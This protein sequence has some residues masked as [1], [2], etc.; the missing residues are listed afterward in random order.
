MLDK[1]NFSIEVAVTN[2]GGAM[3]SDTISKNGRSLKCQISRRNK[4]GL[5][6]IVCLFFVGTLST[7]AQQSKP[8]I[9]VIDLSK[10]DIYNNNQAMNLTGLLTTDLVN[11]R[12]YVV[13]ERSR[14][15]QIINELGLQ[16]TQN[17]SARAAEIGNLLGVS[18]IITGELVADGPALRAN[19][20]LIDVESGGIEA[21]VSVDNAVRDKNGKIKLVCKGCR[22][23]EI[24]DEEFAQKILVALLN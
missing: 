8:K 18:K 4:W 1:S 14:V 13:M 11:T 10:S 17:A 7:Y 2:C 5:L 6:F 24:S 19:I 9:A 16:N 15:Q 21:A 3:E 12:K 20:R 22:A 23:Y